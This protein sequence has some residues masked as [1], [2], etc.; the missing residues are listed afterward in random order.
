MAAKFTT[1]KLRLSRIRA[2]SFAIK[3]NRDLIELARKR[4][5]AHEEETR[6]LKEALFDAQD[7]NNAAVFAAQEGFL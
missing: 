2:L 6:L 7:A 5:A 4:I 1:R 3:K